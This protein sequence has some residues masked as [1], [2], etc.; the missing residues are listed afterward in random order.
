M[1]DSDQFRTWR[2]HPQTVAF[3][4]FLRDYRQSRMEMWARG[5]AG[6]HQAQE[7]AKCQLLHDLI[8]LDDD[9]VSE[10]YRQQSKGSD[11]AHGNQEAG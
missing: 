2:E 11:D 10:F 1:I 6:E 9:A 3:F 5:A 8:N 4:Q 7:M